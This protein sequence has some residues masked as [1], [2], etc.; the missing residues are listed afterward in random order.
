MLER[1]DQPL[2][3]D[4]A[5]ARKLPDATHG[6]YGLSSC[7]QVIDFGQAPLVQEADQLLT[8]PAIGFPLG[9]ARYSDWTEP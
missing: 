9:R 8:S 6:R 7:Q 3:V 4:E 5:Q 1:L 2:G